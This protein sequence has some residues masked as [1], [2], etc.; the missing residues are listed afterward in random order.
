MSS[1]PGLFNATA[2]HIHAREE[3][4]FTNPTAFCQIGLSA[5]CHN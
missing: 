1:K 3:V 4:T 5:E 2:A